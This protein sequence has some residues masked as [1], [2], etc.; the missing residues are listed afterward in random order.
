MTVARPDPAT[1]RPDWS[2][3]H[4]A[5]QTA[6]SQAAP[7]HTDHRPIV[8]LVA[9]E[10][11]GVVFTSLAAQ[12]TPELCDH[13]TID[14]VDAT[15]TRYRV[16]YPRPTPAPIQDAGASPP[17]RPAVTAGHLIRVPFAHPTP[18][19]INHPSEQGDGPALTW[20]VNL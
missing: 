5:H 18:G 8:R 14:I 15:H 13:C 2:L 7:P 3:P 19:D 11:P 9:S 12:C 1:G 6:G 10:Q 16:A 17:R 20:R 4:A